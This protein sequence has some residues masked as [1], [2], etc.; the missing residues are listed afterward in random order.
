MNR[1]FFINLNAKRIDFVQ[2][3]PF[4]RIYGNEMLCKLFNNIFAAFLIIF[5]CFNNFLQKIDIQKKS[6][7]L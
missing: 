6:D 2:N 1:L 3:R 4:E 5:Y 7:I